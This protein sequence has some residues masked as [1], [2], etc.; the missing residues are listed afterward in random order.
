MPIAYVNESNIQYEQFYT[1]EKKDSEKKDSEKKDKDYRTKH[2]L[3]I[4]GIG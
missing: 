1:E 4:H 2:I 3:F